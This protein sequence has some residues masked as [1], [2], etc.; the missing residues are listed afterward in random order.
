MGGSNLCPVR[1]TIVSR[2]PAAGSKPLGFRGCGLRGGFDC[3]DAILEIN[4][5]FLQAKETC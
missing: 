1:P 2:R 5:V 3:S 4:E